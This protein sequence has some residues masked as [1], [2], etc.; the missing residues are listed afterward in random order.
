MIH[1]ALKPRHAVVLAFALVAPG[2]CTKAEDETPGKPHVNASTGVVGSVAFR[3]T[4][5][6]I[7]TVVSRPGSIALLSAPAATRVSNVLV[8]GGQ[9]VKKG[10]PLVEFERAPFEAREASAEAALQAAERAHQRA[11]RLVA[12]G[13]A[14]RK[15]EEQAS[16]DLARARADAVQAR[17]EAQLS[18]LE[19]PIDGIVTKMTAV[20]GAS[21]DASQP[22]VE[23]ADPSAVDI[24]VQVTPDQAAQLHVGASAAIRS[25]QGTDAE[26]LG[27]ATV[28]DVGGA[29][30]AD[31]RAVAVRLRGAG[32]KRALR[33]GES[34]TAEV[35]VA[36]FAKATVVPVKALVPD[37]EGFKVFSVDENGIAH[38]VKVALG[39]RSNGMARVIDGIKAGQIIVVDGAFGMT[40]GGKIANIS[41]EDDD[42]DPGAPPKADAKAAAKGDSTKKPDTGK[43]P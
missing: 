38:E 4:I 14:A 20:M 2:A 16:A 22:V 17:R 23:V 9:R 11:Q 5:S 32:L 25:G 33:I 39:G 37:G 26:A 10:A 27:N 35:T 3:E 21:V 29:V 28:Q 30:D 7:G 42:E 12:E 34:I 31:S 19:S 8:V 24:V 1:A 15:D 18:R 13:I 40:D 41:D 43:K 6:A 36:E